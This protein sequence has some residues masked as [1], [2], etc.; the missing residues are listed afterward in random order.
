[1]LRMLKVCIAGSPCSDE[2]SQHGYLHDVSYYAEVHIML[3]YICGCPYAD[4]H[5]NDKKS[6]R[7]SAASSTKEEAKRA[8]ELQPMADPPGDAVVNATGLVMTMLLQM[9]LSAVSPAV[10]HEPASP[11]ACCAAM[12]HSHVASAAKLTLPIC[13]L[14]MIRSMITNRYGAFH[15]GPGSGSES[16]LQITVAGYF[17]SIIR[18]GHCITVCFLFVDYCAFHDVAQAC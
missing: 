7:S 9:V 12:L 14:S 5:M 13:I 1:M 3:R 17:L 8:V 15:L 16:I 6:A 10:A 18:P 2:S 4:T 11:L